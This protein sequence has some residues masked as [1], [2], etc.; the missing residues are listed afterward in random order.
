[1]H[2]ILAFCFRFKAGSANFVRYV[3]AL[4]DET[5]RVAGLPQ[6]VTLVDFC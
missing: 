4:Y 6:S 3:L 5:I 2:F 1:M